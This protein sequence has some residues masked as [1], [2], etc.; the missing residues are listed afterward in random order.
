MKLDLSFWLK[1]SAFLCGLQNST[2]YCDKRQVLVLK[3]LKDIFQLQQ[4]T[5][6]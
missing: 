3:L 5:F 4:T 1:L 2:K 6:Y